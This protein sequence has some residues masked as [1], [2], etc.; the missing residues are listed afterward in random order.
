MVT[1]IINTY[2][3]AFSICV[4]NLKKK[5]TAPS[6]PHLE[7]GSIPLY[8]KDCCLLEGAGIGGAFPTK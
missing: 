1:I 3:S 6:S 4:Q 5:N 7:T 2:K 8:M